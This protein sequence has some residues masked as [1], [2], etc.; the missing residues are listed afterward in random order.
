MKRKCTDCGK[1]HVITKKDKREIKER[2]GRILYG[3]NV[4]WSCLL[5]AE[6]DADE[7]KVYLGG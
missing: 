4:C 1:T 6:F 7:N 3:E 2:S 5:W